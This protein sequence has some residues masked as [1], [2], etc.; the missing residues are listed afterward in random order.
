MKF[1][2]L[3]NWLCVPDNH[4]LCQSCLS[5]HVLW[6]IC[7]SVFCLTSE[8]HPI[9]QYQ[10]SSDVFFF[11]EKILSRKMLWYCD[12]WIWAS[13]S[14]RQCPLLAGWNPLLHLLQMKFPAMQTAVRSSRPTIAP[15]TAPAG[16]PAGEARTIT[17]H[18]HFELNHIV[19]T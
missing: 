13:S 18:S 5:E 16:N 3:S 6:A 10:Y 1:F 2:Y 15:V 8:L 11:F 17:E 4:Q 7:I 19:A 12:Q 9:Q 14:I